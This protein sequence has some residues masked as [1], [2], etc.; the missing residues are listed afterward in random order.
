MYNLIW[1]N[2]YAPRKIIDLIFSFKYAIIL[3]VDLKK[4][5]ISNKPIFKIG[6]EYEL[7][8]VIDLT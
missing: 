2:T 1:G 3:F 8:E 6:L 4:L 7:I 5:E